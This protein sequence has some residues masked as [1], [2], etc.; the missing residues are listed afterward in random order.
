M[1][2][3][4]NKLAG[5]AGSLR[6]KTTD[7][8]KTMDYRIEIDRLEEEIE[9]LYMDIGEIVCQYLDSGEKVNFAGE[10]NNKYNKIKMLRKGIRHKKHILSQTMK[11]TLYCKNCGEIMEEGIRFCPICGEKL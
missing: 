6:T 3:F 8:I 5:T 9:I 1:D 7:F 10:I 4:A 11:N 2:E